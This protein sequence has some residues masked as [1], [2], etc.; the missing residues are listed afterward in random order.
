[1]KK[2][3]YFVVALA[4]WFPSFAAVSAQE[5]KA[6][7]PGIAAPAPSFSQAELELKVQEK[8]IATMKEYHSS[9]LDTVYWALGTVATV[10][11]LLVGFGWLA[12]FKFHE[13]EKQR[14]KDELD[15]KIK[16]AL[17]SIETRLSSNEVQVINSVDSRLDSHFTRVARDIDIARAE[18]AGMNERISTTIEQFKSQLAT[19]EKAKSRSEIA[20]SEMEAALRQVEEHVWELKGIPIN[21]LI[22]QTQGL[23]AAIK[24][25]NRFYVASA[26]E[27]MEKTITTSILPDKKDVDAKM[28]KRIS[29]DVANASAI[30]PVAA[31]TVSE[32][33]EQIQVKPE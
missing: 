32:L 1:M 9:L 21:M 29:E 17:A 2:I 23:R 33:L 28:L 26:L 30:E 15:G 18:A 24:A 22:T 5:T 12:N 4:F 8:Q 6:A 27:R 14:L 16:E 10:A 31:A 13:S 25:S 20:D 11:V 3:F 7:R 19:L